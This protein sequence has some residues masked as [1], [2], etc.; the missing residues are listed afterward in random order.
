MII[1]RNNIIPF[2]GFDAMTIWPF[3][4]IRKGEMLTPRII[5][6]EEIHGEQQ[7][8]ILLILLFLGAS[9]VLI[10]AEVLVLFSV[11]SGVFLSVSVVFSD[12]D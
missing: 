5:R 3:I 8:E 10:K 7:K 11:E 2:E 4:F 12:E 1:I 6:H 9:V